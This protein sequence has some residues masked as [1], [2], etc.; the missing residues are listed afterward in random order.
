MRSGEVALWLDGSI[1][2]AGPLG[3]PIDTENFDAVSINVDDSR[4]IVKLGIVTAEQIREV[5]ATWW[6]R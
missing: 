6:E 1:V 2:W 5:L 4:Q 3:A